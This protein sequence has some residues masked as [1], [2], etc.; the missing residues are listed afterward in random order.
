MKAPL[1]KRAVRRAGGLER[2]S[3]P[4][5]HESLFVVSGINGAGSRSA[6]FMLLARLSKKT[7]PETF[8]H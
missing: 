2:V 3:R 6:T 5:R 4:R 8:G 1:L 7:I